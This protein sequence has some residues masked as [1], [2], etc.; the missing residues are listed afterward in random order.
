MNLPNKIT[1]SRV[2]LVPIFMIFVIPLPDWLLN[3]ELL[4]FIHPQMLSI[5]RFIVYYGNYIAAFIYIIAAITDGVDGYI[6]RKRKEIT[7]LGKFLDPI[8]D[9]LLVTAALIV[10]LIRNDVTGWAAMI[11]IG[12]EFIV[13]GLRLVAAGEGIVIAASKMGKLKTITQLIA[14]V[15]SLLDNYPLSLFTS[16]RFDQVAMFIAVIITIYSGYDYYKK[17]INVISSNL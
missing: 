3:G 13:T 7:R 6:A 17:N 8:A 10:L 1:L 12:R 5:N 11:I 16:F 15:A 14:V 9:K 4:R 2:F